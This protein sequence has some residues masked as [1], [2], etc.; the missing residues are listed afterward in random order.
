MLGTLFWLAI[1]FF[2]IAI[3]AWLVGAPRCS[4]SQRRRGENAALCLPDSVRPVH[5]S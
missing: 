1:V 4:G 3:V 2:I 5:D